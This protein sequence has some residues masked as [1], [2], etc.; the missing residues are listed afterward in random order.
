MQMIELAKQVAELQRETAQLKIEN[1]QVLKDKED[2]VQANLKVFMHT[3]AP[4][5]SYL[6]DAQENCSDEPADSRPD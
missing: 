2:M 1:A 5:A 3:P 4:I 6:A